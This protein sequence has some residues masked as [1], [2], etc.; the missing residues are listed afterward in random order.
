L[1]VGSGF[2]WS[3]EAAFSRVIGF[4]GFYSFVDLVDQFSHDCDDDLF[5]LLKAVTDV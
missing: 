3:Y 2:G 1:L 4:S 5:L